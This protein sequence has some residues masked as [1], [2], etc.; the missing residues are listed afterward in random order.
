MRAR[1]WIDK[2]TQNSLLVKMVA[3]LLTGLS[4]SQLRSDIDI[5]VGKIRLKKPWIQP[6]DGPLS[7]TNAWL[8]QFY[9]DG[10]KSVGQG[11]YKNDW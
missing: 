10:S 4:A 1:S 8:N 9:S 11:C 3:W 5:L 2:T 6:G 7:R